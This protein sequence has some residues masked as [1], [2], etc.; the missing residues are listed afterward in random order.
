MEVEGRNRE[1]CLVSERTVGLTASKNLSPPP[2]TH[3][4]GKISFPLKS[5]P[6]LLPPENSFL[7]APWLRVQSLSASLK[8][9]S[10]RY[11]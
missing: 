10:S 3:P 5:R 8:T 1:A 9:C 7:A 4:P 11:F 6:Y 2:H